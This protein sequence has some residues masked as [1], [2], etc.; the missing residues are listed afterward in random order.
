MVGEGDRR[1]GRR[2]LSDLVGRP[3]QTIGGAANEVL[4]VR[5]DD[6]VVATARS[7][8][9]QPVPIAWVQ[10]ALDRLHAEE[11]LQIDPS[12]VG[13][14]SG[15]IG[16]VLRTLP[17]TR[18]EQNP[19]RIVLAETLP[20]WDVPIGAFLSRAERNARFGGALYGG[21]EPSSGSPNVFVYS[22]PSRGEAYGYNYDG[23]ADDGRLFFYTGEGSEGDQPMNHGNRAILEHRD[24]GRSLRLFVADGW[25][26]GTGQ[27]NQRYIGEFEVDRVNPYSLA[28]APDARGE[29]RT[30][31]VFRLRPLGDVLRRDSDKSPFSEPQHEGAASQV[32]AEENV[33]TSFEVTPRE[34]TTATR[35]EGEMVDRYI[36]WLGA[37]HVVSRWKLRPPGELRSL[38]TDIYDDSENIL[39][40]AKGTT[41]R[42]AIRMAIGQ[43]L[44]YRRH[45]ARPGMR[46]AILLPHR[47]SADLVDLAA[48]LGIAVV[49]EGARGSFESIEPQLL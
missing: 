41:T 28:E 22:D 4:E 42:G 46:L 14:R 49:A 25:V 45:I 3:I 40:E 17:N 32:A 44:D 33:A 6:V 26:E 43:L 35:R 39:Y 47:P 7:P 20:E 27:R 8:L 18:V 48:S 1:D 31:F 11:E 21:I 9:G 13:H 24:R 15:F 38:L 36:A 30:V 12:T 37:G 10:D 19:L 34:G 23:W 29:D 2:L 16:A 5:D